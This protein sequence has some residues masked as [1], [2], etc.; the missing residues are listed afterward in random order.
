M[1][2]VMRTREQ[3]NREQ[4]GRN[5]IAKVR[6]MSVVLVQKARG[7]EAEP[8]MKRH[9]KNSMKKEPASKRPVAAAQVSTVE[10]PALVPAPCGAATAALDA[11]GWQAALV[12][13]GK[14]GLAN[15]RGAESP[16][17][18]QSC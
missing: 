9:A 13:F 15:A 5:A 6:R 2:T 16:R 10:L 18:G 8:K 4:G 1:D 3:W 17:D 12:A 7:R 14:S 11:D